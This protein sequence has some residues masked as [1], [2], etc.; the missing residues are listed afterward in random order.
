MS[1]RR[2]R[3]RKTRGGFRLGVWLF[4][5]LAA[6]GAGA[7]FGRVPIAERVATA[8]IERAG[9][10]PASL[11]LT[12]IDLD[13]VEVADLDFLLGSIGRLA[14]DYRLNGDLTR[15]HI[16]DA[17]L[18]LSA[19]SPQDGTA[20]VSLTL[21]AQTIALERVRITAD[22][23]G[24]KAVATI[25]GLIETLPVLSGDIDFALTTPTGDL[26]GQFQAGL[27]PD[28]GLKGKLDVAGGDL[29]FADIAVSG[30][31]VA[32][33]FG[34]AEGGLVT[35]GSFSIDASAGIVVGDDYAAEPAAKALTGRYSLK[36]ETLTLEELGGS[37]HVNAAKATG[38][39]QLETGTIALQPEASRVTYDL[40]E[41]AYSY[42]LATSPFALDLRLEAAGKTV[43]LSIAG[44]GLSLSGDAAALSLVVSGG[45]LTSPGHNVAISGIDGTLKSQDDDWR[46]EATIGTLRHLG[47]PALITP[48]SGEITGRLRGDLIEGKVSAAHGTEPVAIAAIVK[49]DLASGAGEAA[50][51][52]DR[53][54]L[55]DVSIEYLSPAYAE[56]VSAASG[57]ISFTGPVRWGPDGLSSDI[58]VAFEDV[59]FK[60]G[61]ITVSA[62]NGSIVLDSLVPPGTRPT[63]H[64]TAVLD[65]SP[66]GKMPVD[67]KFQLKE[68]KVEIETVDLSVFGGA[69]TARAAS[70][71]ASKGSGGI[72]LQLTEIDL[73][74]IFDLIDL[75]EVSGT[76]RVSGGL[77]VRLEA[78]RVAIKA[79]KLKA[80]EPGVLRISGDALAGQLGGAGETVDL[81]IQ[82]LSNFE[83]ERLELE[84]DKPFEGDGV[85]KFKIEGANPDVLDGHPFVF[86]VNLTSDFDKLAS[87]LFEV[88]KAA[89][90]ALQW[91]T[92]Q[93]TR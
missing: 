53:V 54:T 59:G 31:S 67:L 62:L 24:G 89:D 44:E 50:V 41:G 6:L 92:Q 91:G 19:L 56:T 29:D 38:F 34:S 73:A 33:V 51:T 20:E 71:D 12:S 23:P 63:Q 49:H 27:Q 88:A 1:K 21:P 84:A 40:G 36:G 68:G 66:V 13:G 87:V 58:A 18:D 79:G 26:T 39:G 15:I 2:S 37:L 5:F 11:T 55:D 69:I 35:E 82:A 57:T 74:A 52:L 47:E 83:Y 30:L 77:P 86:N 78:G 64:L 22:I 48:F 17:D 60:N 4:V 32:A 43:P 93:G 10:G 65:I 72:D 3:R 9:Y 70:F 7:W 16:A 75:E 90:K 81:A 42:A 61:T 85:V 8:L 80:A 45:G 76:G 46:V 28:G 25:A 14:V